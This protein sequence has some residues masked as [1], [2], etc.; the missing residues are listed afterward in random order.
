[1]STRQQRT[2]YLRQ[3]LP[4][5]SPEALNALLWTID[6]TSGAELQLKVSGQMNGLVLNGFPAIVARN[7]T[8]H[9][10]ACVQLTSPSPDDYALFTV[11][12]DGVL[13]NADLYTLAIPS[14]AIRNQWGGCLAPSKQAFPTPFIFSDEIVMQVTYWDASVLRV[15]FISQFLPVCIGPNAIVQ[16]ETTADV[17]TFEGWLGNEAEFVFPLGLNAGDLITWPGN[18]NS[19]KNQFGGTL[20][21]GS[22]TLA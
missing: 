2:S 7:S 14:Q 6:S 13:A 20:N 16:N 3:R 1:M 12:F 5:S 8:R 18:Q 4:T 9:S 10:I 19:F 22:T 17:A 15:D 21:A 11:T